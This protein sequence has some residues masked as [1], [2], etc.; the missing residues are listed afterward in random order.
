[1]MGGMCRV[2]PI[3]AQQ[4]RQP[5][6]RE[7]ARMADQPDRTFEEVSSTLAA[8]PGARM[9]EGDD[10]LPA[11][12]DLALIEEAVRWINR[13]VRDTRLRGAVEIGDYILLHF[14][15][16]SVEEAR[17][18]NPH[19]RRS[20]RKLCA[21]PELAVSATTLKNCVGLAVQRRQL[22]PQ[23][24]ER[25]GY[26]HHIALLPVSDGA[27]KQELARQAAEERLSVRALRARI[28]ARIRPRRGRRASPALD[29]F[30]RLRRTFDAP[31][32]KQWLAPPQLAQLSD[33]EAERAEAT[34]TELRETIGQALSELRKRS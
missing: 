13:K 28:R 31:T 14:F 10:E 8:W 11:D 33:A 32:V 3:A 12:R 21:H 25:L 16:G 7:E 26:S 27:V 18:H 29:A 20:F 24:F 6:E 1:M 4:R 2:E 23:L 22:D 17:S 15:G 5:G 9:P 34:L 30:S 19:K